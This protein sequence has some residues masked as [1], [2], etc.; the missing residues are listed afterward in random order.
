MEGSRDRDHPNLTPEQA[1]Q[2]KKDMDEI[3]AG[4]GA[5]VTVVAIKV[6]KN[7]PDSFG[8]VMRLVRKLTQGDCN[9]PNCDSCTYERERKALQDR[10]M[11]EASDEV[12]R[13]RAAWETRAATEIAK[14]RLD[15]MKKI[16]EKNKQEKKKS[17]QE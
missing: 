1:A 3:G 5:G 6:D 15:F 11:K 13:L 17:D 10:L 7:D 2:V 14:F 16:A 4:L 8:D 12:D 9:K